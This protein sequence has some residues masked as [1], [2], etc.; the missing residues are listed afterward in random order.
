MP[1]KEHLLCL[2]L[3]FSIRLGACISFSLLFNSC[4]TKWVLSVLVTVSIFLREYYNKYDYYLLYK[5][6][7]EIC[8]S[9]CCIAD[10]GFWQKLSW[11]LS[12]DMRVCGWGGL[13]CYMQNADLCVCKRTQFRG[14]DQKKLWMRK[15]KCEKRQDGQS[16]A[17]E[18]RKLQQISV[19]HPKPTGH[20]EYCSLEFTHF[21]WWAEGSS[22]LSPSSSAW[23]CQTWQSLWDLACQTC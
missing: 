12:A 5:C 3:L 20:S 9:L 8:Q 17:T 16:I 7:S 23:F 14:N 19:P 4:E 11:H 2:T 21:L 15:L 22:L 18:E 1:P 13:G 10:G 6:I